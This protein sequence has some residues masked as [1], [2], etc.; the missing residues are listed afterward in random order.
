MIVDDQSLRSA[1]YPSW[2]TRTT[3]PIRH[4]G[5]DCHFRLREGGVSKNSLFPAGSAGRGGAGLHFPA[6]FRR[7]APRCLVWDVSAEVGS[8]DRSQDSPWDLSEAVLGSPSGQAPEGRV[9]IVGTGRG[10]L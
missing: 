3:F 1:A 6:G 7:R 10:G 5:F 2:S 8:G 9:E 4:C